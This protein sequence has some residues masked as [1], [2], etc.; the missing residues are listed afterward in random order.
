MTTHEQQLRKMC[1]DDL[2]WRCRDLEVD[3]LD[4]RRKI[5]AIHSIT[6]CMYGKGI[7]RGRRLK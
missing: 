4:L 7:P 1:K 6:V 2:V 3:K 5:N